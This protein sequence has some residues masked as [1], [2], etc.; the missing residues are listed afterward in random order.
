MRIYFL[1]KLLSLFYEE[2]F[3][4]P[5]SNPSFPPI[6]IL[7]KFLRIILFSMLEAMIDYSML[8]EHLSRSF[9]LN[10]K[11]LNLNIW[12]LFNILKPR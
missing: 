7:Q 9:K 5:L 2:V 3:Y 4:T 10:S 12:H 1:R 6:K 11:Q 8:I